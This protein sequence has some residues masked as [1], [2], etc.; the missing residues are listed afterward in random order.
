[1]GWIGYKGNQPMQDSQI[2]T[3]PTRRKLY[4]FT[5]YLQNALYQPSTVPRA[6]DIGKTADKIPALS[7]FM[8]WAWVGDSYKEK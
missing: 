3:N 4:A 5:R 7:E 2:E 8:L 6:G 1:M